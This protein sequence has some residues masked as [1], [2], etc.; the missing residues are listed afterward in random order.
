M[1]DTL[2][3]KSLSPYA[4]KLLYIPTS[5]RASFLQS[6]RNILNKDV[7]V[8]PAGEIKRP[9]NS[10]ILAKDKDC[11]CQ[12]KL[13]YAVQCQHEIFFDRRFILNR[14]AS[15]WLHNH[16]FFENTLNYQQHI[17]H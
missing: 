15:R 4:Y 13:D 12:F 16:V 14:Y 1:D 7:T 10:Y 6:E 2:A 8:W 3:E 5:K 17:C 11:T 9:S